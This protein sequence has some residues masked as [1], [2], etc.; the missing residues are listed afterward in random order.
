MR[1]IVEAWT[2]VATLVAG[3]PSLVS[4]LYGKGVRYKQYLAALE[5]AVALGHFWYVD[6]GADGQY[7]F[8]V[9]IDEDPP[10]EL[11]PM[12]QPL[13]TVPDFKVPTGRLLVTGAEDFM[14][15]T[16]HDAPMGRALQV[17]PGRYALTAYECDY[18]EDF[19]DK[20]F[21]GVATPAQQAAR[22]FGGRIQQY[23]M[24]LTVLALVGGCVASR[25]MHAWTPILLGLGVVVAG[26]AAQSAYCRREPYASAERL[27]R[28]IETQWPSY[29]LVLKSLP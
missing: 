29:V 25:R 14:G 24:L 21:A 16:R 23:C 7:L 3:D 27:F 8:H 12:L 22:D 28:E 10:R 11:Q 6:T 15:D 9:F 13:S 17:T 2:D 5:R 18:E 4:G 26:W 20:I 1:E 19:S